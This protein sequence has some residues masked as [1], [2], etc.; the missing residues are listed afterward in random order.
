MI[1][2]HPFC[3]SLQ[4]QVRLGKTAR[5][6]PP[7]KF[8]AP[9]YPRWFYA[10]P[11]NESLASTETLIDE[12]GD[13]VL[14]PVNARQAL[15]CLRLEPYEGKLSRTV[16]RREQLGNPP[17]PAVGILM[18]CKNRQKPTAAT[19]PAKPTPSRTEPQQSCPAHTPSL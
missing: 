15:T 4:H 10:W 12:L 2:V 7:K 6:L 1:V 17:N 13:N 11:I 16:L 8:S 14:N 5:F 9:I 18:I 19:Q 3:K